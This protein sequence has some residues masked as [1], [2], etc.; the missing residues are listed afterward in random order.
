MRLKNKKVL[1]TGSD[2]FIGSHLVE[3]L[4]DEGASVRAFVYYNSFG[5]WGWLDTLPERKLKG[6]EVHAG[7]VRDPASVDAAMKG[8]DAVFHLAALIGIPYSYSSPDS[9]VSTNTYGTLNILQAARRR[10][11]ER[12]IVTSTSEVYGTAR[13]APIDELH[14]MQ[15][16]SPYS[17]TKIAADALAES[18]C[19]SFALPVVIARP[20]NAYGPRQSA[21]AVIPT[22]ISQLLKGPVVRLGSLSPLRDFNYVGDICDGMVALAKCEKAVGKA[23]NIG[24][25]KEVSIRELTRT[26]VKKIRPGARI[27]SDDQRVRPV[28]SEVGRLICDNRLIKK[29]TGW[30]PRVGL[31]EGLT[32]TLEWMRNEK[33]RGYKPD[34]YNL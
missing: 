22:V 1:V 4:L 3:R 19:R 29:L 28:K 11:A 13:Y 8:V 33:G 15:P 34:I 23:V 26:L 30:S 9:Y 5:S 6:I 7:D 25:G 17:A 20:F 16:Q 12:I 21:R 14:P 10:G 18:F 32:K 2:G 24:S 31:E 27:V